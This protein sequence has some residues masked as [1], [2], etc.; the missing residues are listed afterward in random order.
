MASKKKR[1][2]NMPL[3]GDILVD[4]L[5][6]ILIE[7]L[8]KTIE[9]VR[10]KKVLRD[11]DNRRKELH[12]LLIEGK[13]Y[14]GK[15]KHKVKKAPLVKTLIHEL[16]HAVTDVEV[17]KEWKIRRLERVLYI[18]FTDAQKRFLR[19]YIPKHEVKE[20]PSAG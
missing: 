4:T 14:L 18:R 15:H 3:S 6:E 20:E 12:G 1:P 2:K 11:P 5:F 7:A 9:A 10:M 19:K 13:I 16:L 8:E 17:V